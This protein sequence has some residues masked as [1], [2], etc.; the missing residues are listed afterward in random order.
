MSRADGARSR[1]QHDTRGRW[2]IRPAAFDE[3][4]AGIVG[5]K[6]ISRT[7]GFAHDAGHWAGCRGA[8]MNAQVTPADS[9]GLEHYAPAIGRLSRG[10]FWLVRHF[11]SA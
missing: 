11:I 5:Q 2:T 8:A 6:T 4:S 3:I 9:P 7:R 1:S 10:A